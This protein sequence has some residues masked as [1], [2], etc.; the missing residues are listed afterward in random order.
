MKS[1]HKFL[2]I[3]SLLVILL[4]GFTS[5]LIQEK[6]RIR[7][8][9]EVVQSLTAVLDTTHQTIKSWV[10][11]HKAEVNVWANT[12]KIYHL[13]EQL[14]GLS[15]TPEALRSSVVQQQIRDIL[16]PLWTGADYRGFY[17]IS[18]DY[19]NLA[20]SREDHIGTINALITKQNFYQKI[21]TGTP[22]ISLPEL[23]TV[24]LKDKDGVLQND[25]PVMFAGA[26]IKNKAG[27]VIA[28]LAFQLD[29]IEEFTSILQQGR[30]GTTGETYA[31]DEQGRLI[32]NSR[33]VD[34]LH[35]IGL[36]EINKPAIVNI[37]I[38][39]P[40]VLLNKDER[41]LTTI[42]QLPFTRM[43]ASALAGESGSDLQ[44]YRDYRG[45]SVV[46]VWRW[47][48]EL[49]IGIATEQDKQEAYR[50]I[51]NMQSVIL[52]LTILA[53][54][55]S[56]GLI[57]LQAFY[58]RMK[59]AVEQK[60]D[61]EA[62]LRS[63]LESVGEGVFGVDTEGN[64][65]FINS[66]GLHLLGYSDASELVGKNIHALIHHTRVDG[67]PCPDDECRIYDAYRQGKSFFVDDEILW[68]ADNTSFQVEYYSNVVYSD[69]KIT[70]SVATFTDITSRRQAENTLRQSETKYRQIFNS[71]LDVYA[72]IALDGTI[73]EVSPS[74][75]AH[76]GYT[77][78][79][80]LGSF[81][82]DYYANP[83]D[84]EALLA[85][86]HQD[87]IINDYEATLID[88][89]GTIRPFSFTGRVIT[90]ESGKPVK[91][92]GVMRD[93]A[94]RKHSEN[95]LR[96]AHDILER[97]VQE[98]TAELEVINEELRHEIEERKLVERALR[99]EHDKA[100]RYLDTVEAIIVSLDPEGRVTLINRK[101]CEILGYTE[102]ELLGKNWFAMCLPQPEGLEL[103]YPLFEEIMSGNL[104][105][106]EYYEN[107]VL[108]RDGVRRLIAWHNNYLRN[109]EGNISGTLSAG[110]DI[111]NRVQAEEQARQHQ[112]ELAHMARLNIMGE[113]AT[114]I[115]H[116]LNQPL[117][118]IVT[119]SDVALRILKAGTE[120]SEKLQEAI[121]GSR[122]QAQ[123][124]AEIIRHLRQLVSKQ[125]PQSKVVSLNE[126]V[127]EA[128]KFIRTD[129]KQHH[130]SIKLS[131]DE[132]IPLV[133]ID[134][135]QI[136]QVILN[137]VRNS[138]E[139]M[140]QALTP[141]R[142][143]TIHTELNK[144]KL[145]Q[146]TVSDSGP[147]LDEKAQREIFKPFVTTKTDAGMGMGLSISRSIIEAHDGKLWVE[148]A[149]G[150]GAKFCFTLP[151]TEAAS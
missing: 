15:A 22:A 16:H 10:N 107:Y 91:L 82:G 35:H 9:Q 8:E 27:S 44:G 113:M 26:P 88:K 6:L 73:L 146:V 108:T 112:T 70:G 12:T 110:E 111:T 125:A 89:D 120:P 71:I 69:G 115:A 55:L 135:I 30:I 85:Q 80:L 14:L 19:I 99:E 51:Q 92:A 132:Q 50:S 76:T 95:D 43:A 136:E 67:N 66:A 100:Q 65:T 56:F 126:L 114:G 84:R 49:G 104:E 72:E 122:N 134:P 148:S 133:K 45:V 36:L 83:E 58:K 149:P 47:D 121:K 117:S 24:P 98:R 39:D 74:V 123:R 144:E 79:E 68:R 20:A 105:T 60:S 97:R 147:G 96:N 116:E 101:G 93:I 25:L 28:I 139:A 34:E 106:A 53:V 151:I 59:L 137:L 86:I 31:F 124:A 150:Y 37:E 103:V 7:A 131:L 141:D 130:T 94:Q 109:S 48:E 87:G 21:F 29:P 46:G 18:P 40:G 102:Q 54:T 57:M 142:E 77:R 3:A 119:Y 63:L 64:C 118:A 128:A 78:E 52:T 90:D 4:L 145:V 17:I 140:Q 33:F 23:S 138:V 41:S 75:S 11:E 32:S 81:M 2:I 129:I 127:Y 38:R 1:S 42:Q 143:I 61:S 5:W 13:T 62:R